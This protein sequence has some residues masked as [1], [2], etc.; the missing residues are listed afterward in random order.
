MMRKFVLCAVLALAPA[1]AFAAD[2]ATPGTGAKPAP[3]VKAD[4]TVKPDAVKTDAGKTDAVKADTT[5]KS[6]VKTDAVKADAVVKS[7]AKADVAKPVSAAAK[8]AKPGAPADKA[9]QHKGKA[10]DTKAKVAPSEVKTDSKL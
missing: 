9:V 8:D 2:T 6:E 5:I 4:T 1:I 7:D 3:V 10:S